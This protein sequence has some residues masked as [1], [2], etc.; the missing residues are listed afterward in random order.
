MKTSGRANE[1]KAAQTAASG[2]RR[3]AEERLIFQEVAPQIRL[4]A[5][6]LMLP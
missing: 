5:E 4:D 3:S 1:Y 6:R 2:S